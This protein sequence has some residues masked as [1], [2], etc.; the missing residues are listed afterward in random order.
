MK[1]RAAILLA[2]TAMACRGVDSAEHITPSSGMARAIEYARP[3]LTGGIVLEVGPAPGASIDTGLWDVRLADRAHQVLV[4]VDTNRGEQVGL[5][6][7]QLAPLAREMSTAASLAK[8]V[9]P[10]SVLEAAN[11]AVRSLDPDIRPTA[12][13]LTLRDGSLL[14]QVLQ[15]C[16][17]GQRAV[18]LS[19]SDAR[20]LRNEALAER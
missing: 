7:E 13:L 20:V 19:A 9:A 6:P 10:E 17:H 5:E 15:M 3:A 12:L 1:F 14:Y 11:K 18:E 4:R 8:I 16:E 2:L